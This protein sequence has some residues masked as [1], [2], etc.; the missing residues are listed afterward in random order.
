MPLDHQSFV[1]W[2][3]GRF[4]AWARKIGP[5]T[6]TTVQAILSAHKIEQQGYKGCLALIKL[7]DKYSITRLEAACRKALFYTPMPS[8]K[9][10]KT[11]LS[12]GQDKVTAEAELVATDPV[13]SH[14]FTR[15]A[16]YYGRTSR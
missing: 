5:H 4:I 15:G 9:S 11:I 3:A 6:E 7:A 1:Q 12:T 16:S 2:D 13:E 8:Y 14:G 10:V